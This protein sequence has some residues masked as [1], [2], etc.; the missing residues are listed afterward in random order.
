MISIRVRFFGQLLRVVGEE[1]I[2]VECAESSTLKDLLNAVKEMFRD[3]E[4]LLADEDRFR[5]LHLI[6]IDGVDSELLGGLNA[7]LS[8]GSRVDIVPVS[9]GG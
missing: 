2:T 1:E 6:F 5:A 7:H 9:H 3:L 8:D 4:P